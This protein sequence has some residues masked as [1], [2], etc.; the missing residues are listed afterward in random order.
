MEKS[1]ALAMSTYTF[2]FFGTAIFA[3][4]KLSTKLASD[5]VLYTVALGA[6]VILV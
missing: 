6:I 1:N 5:D 3:I 4:R 2:F